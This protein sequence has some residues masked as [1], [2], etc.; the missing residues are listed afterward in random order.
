L[1]HRQDE[2]W[3][4]VGRKWYLKRDKLA[5]APL[6]VNRRD[7]ITQPLVTFVAF[8]PFFAFKDLGRMLGEGKIRTLFSGK[9][10]GEVILKKQ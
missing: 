10:G 2:V 6:T 7:K 1:W 9:S 5:K 3:S 4:S 8:I